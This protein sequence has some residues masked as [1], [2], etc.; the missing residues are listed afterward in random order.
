MKKLQTY[1]TYLGDVGAALPKLAEILGADYSNGLFEKVEDDFASSNLSED[2][3]VLRGKN[4]SLITVKLE[5]YEGYF[6]TEIIGRGK[7]F[8]KAKEILYEYY[9]K[10]GGH[11]DVQERP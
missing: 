7:E 9:I 4:D 10:Q 2:E 11:P 1:G 8:Q 3:W 5:E 6:L